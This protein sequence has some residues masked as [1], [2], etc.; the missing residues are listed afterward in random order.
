[1][2]PRVCGAVLRNETI[3]MVRHRD[4][5]REYWTLPGGGIEPG[6]TPEQAA[7][8]EVFEETGLQGTI[9][10]FLFEEGYLHGTCRC[11][12]LEVS[13][14]QE[15]KLGHDPEDAH[16]KKEQRLLRGVD[17]RHLSQL[18]GDAQVQQVLMVFVPP[19]FAYMSI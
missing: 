11:F 14:E 16:L 2:R 12:L 9:V 10:R 5:E 13:A 8:R 4:A 3:L 17:W 19:R 18:D 1:M 7:V 6:E 15:I